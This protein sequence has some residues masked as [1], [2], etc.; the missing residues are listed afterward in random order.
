M[1]QC[2]SLLSNLNDEY[3]KDA[4]IFDFYENKKLNEIKVGVR[5]IFNQF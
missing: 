5:L 2:I 1:T 4:Y 3:L